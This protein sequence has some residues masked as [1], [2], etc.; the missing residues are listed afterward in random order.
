MAWLEQYTGPWTRREAAHLLRRSSFGASVDQL[1]SA[2]TQGLNATITSLLLPRTLPDPPVDQTTGLVWING[3]NYDGSKGQNYY[4]Q[5]TKAWWVGLMAEGNPSIREKLTLFWM[6]HFATEA[7]VVSKP[8]YTYKL[9]SYLRGN[10]TG[11]F[12]DLVKQVTI[13]E[14]MLIYLNGNTNTKGNANENYGR[15]LQELFTI[16][17]GPEAAPGDYTNY[18]E[19]DVQAAARVLTGW[20]IDR[21]TGTTVF[22]YRQHDTTDKQFSARYQNVVIKGRSGDDAGTVELDELVDLILR[23]PATSQYIVEKLYRWFVN[24]DL[25]PD[26]VTNVILPLAQLLSTDWQIKPVLETLLSSDHFFD[27]SMVGAQLRSPADVVIGTLRTISTVEIPAVSDFTTRFKFLQLFSFAMAAQQMDLLEPPNVAGWP[28]YY[29][30]PGLYNEWLTTATLPQRNAYTDGLMA[31]QIRIG[32]T[33]RYLMDTV[34]FTKTLTNAGSAKPLIT[35]LNELFFALPFSDDT[36]T[37][38]AEEVLMDGGKDYDW[39]KIWQAYID[40]P[41]ADNTKTARTYLNRLFTYLFRMA[42]FQLF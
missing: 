22:Q 3:D 9:L 32:Q 14:A 41:N 33:R 25:N 8:I 42:E 12:K 37:K 35:E 36:T 2:V 15:E 34:V 11:S 39:P 38:L 17:K 4:N 31:Q 26:V 40:D 13:E 19:Q 16:G 30:L 21:L 24:S 7:S 18:T 1:D 23:Q 29:Q 5:G 20:R 28:A 27:A 10:A 6:N